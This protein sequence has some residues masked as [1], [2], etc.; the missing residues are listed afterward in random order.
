MGDLKTNWFK[1]DFAIPDFS[2]ALDYAA[3]AEIWREMGVTSLALKRYRLS[4]PRF[5]NR[6]GLLV[7]GF[8]PASPVDWMDGK[9]LRYRLNAD[10]AWV[11]Y[12]VGQD[13]HDDG[14]DPTPA[15]QGG[16]DGRDLVWPSV[17]PWRN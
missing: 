17:V 14:G 15:A 10:G 2:Q 12:S 13:G 1:N 11:L 16:S 8:L 7:P 5:A 9:P 6:L 4:H 3:R